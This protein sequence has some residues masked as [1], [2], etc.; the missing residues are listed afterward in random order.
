[1][2]PRLT[3]LLHPKTANFRECPGDGAPDAATRRWPCCST[4]WTGVVISDARACLPGVAAGFEAHT[5]G[6][7]RHR[8]H[9]NSRRLG[10]HACAAL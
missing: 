10:H 6:E 3:P 8:D 4:R 7:H 5:R 2:T 9:G 1:M